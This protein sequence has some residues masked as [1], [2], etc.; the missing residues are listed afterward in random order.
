MIYD[1]KTGRKMYFGKIYPII[2]YFMS[3]SNVEEEYN[4]VS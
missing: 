1:G 4:F 3:Y 2:G